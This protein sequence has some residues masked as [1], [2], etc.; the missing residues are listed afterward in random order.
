VLPEFGLLPVRRQIDIIV[1]LRLFEASH[2][3]AAPTAAMPAT[4][5]T[6]EDV[7]NLGGAIEDRTRK[8]NAS[9]ASTALWGATFVSRH[10][11][12][13]SALTPRFWT[14]VVQSSGSK[15][16]ERVGAV[17]ARKKQSRY[18]RSCVRASDWWQS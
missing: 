5:A 10:D 9:R 18:K 8:R 14:F 11:L 3:R 2:S 17:N 15:I 13:T 1:T 7:F 4:A 6:P 16:F 12:G